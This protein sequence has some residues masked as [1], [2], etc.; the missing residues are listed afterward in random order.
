M[1]I[2]VVVAVAIVIISLKKH[3]PMAAHIV[4]ERGVDRHP[5]PCSSTEQLVSVHTEAV[6]GLRLLFDRT[7]L[8]ATVNCP[9]PDC[10]VK[11]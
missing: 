9:H 10:L 6:D 3:P 4:K 1:I 5:I 7:H 8:L 2:I 11:R